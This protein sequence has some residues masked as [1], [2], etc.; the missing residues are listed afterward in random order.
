M[1]GGRID[2]LQCGW[3]A[4]FCHFERSDIVPEG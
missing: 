3:G 4:H 2:E 1:A